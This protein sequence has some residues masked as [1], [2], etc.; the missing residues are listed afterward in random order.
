MFADS[1]FGY[2]SQVRFY[3]SYSVTP[4]HYLSE[5]PQSLSN[6]VTA[7]LKSRSELQEENLQLQEE[8]L[9]QQYQL[10]KIDH[11]TAE[12][13]RLNELLNSSAIVDDIVVRAQL[14]SESPDPFRKQVLINKGSIHGVYDGQ[15]VLD[16]DGLFGQVVSIEPYYSWVQLITDPQHSTPVQVN[17]NGIRAVVSG[18]QSSL[19]EMVMNNMTGNAD[20]EVGDMLV[21]SGLGQ[22]FPAG[23]KVGVITRIVRDPGQPFARVGSETLRASHGIWVIVASFLAASLLLV[24]PLPNWLEYY[25][26]EWMALV[27]IYWAMALPHKIGLAS[28]WALGFFVDVLEGSL[29]GLNGLVLALVTYLALSLY[30]RLRMFTMLQQASTVFMLVGIHQLVSFWILTVSNQNTSP[31]LMFLVSAVTS[32]IIWPIVF[33]ILRYLR[34]TFRVV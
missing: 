24:M 17:R 20:I 26:P 34:R 3:A 32:A 15:P 23:Y 11:L 25:R 9:L 29:L 33:Y 16:A 2:M 14:V 13:E 21:T 18:T 10:Q 4:I 7:I 31:N 1:R 28:A 27:V 30:Q 8:L 22:R 12:N 5:I 19:H 6:Q